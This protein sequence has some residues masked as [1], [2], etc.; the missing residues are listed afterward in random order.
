MKALNFKGNKQKVKEGGKGRNLS[1]C[2]LLLFS[3]FLSVL[4]IILQF[5]Y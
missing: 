5:I 2:S 4:K 1:T 3:I